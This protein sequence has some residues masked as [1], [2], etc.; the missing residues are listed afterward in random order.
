MEGREIRLKLHKVSV[1]KLDYFD[2]EE[3]ALCAF[4]GFFCVDVRTSFLT[5]CT[6][7]CHDMYS[8]LFPHF[9]LKRVNF[10]RM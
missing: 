8:F 1:D 5:P 4:T 3:V 7:C 6:C 9:R 10:S 2:A